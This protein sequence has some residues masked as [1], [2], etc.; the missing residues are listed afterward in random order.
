MA[1]ESFANFDLLILRDGVGYQARVLDSPVGNAKTCFELPFTAAELEHFAWL[2]PHISRHLKSA[3]QSAQAP[4]DVQTFGSRLFGAVF[5]GEVG[6]L[7]VRSLDASK[8]TGLRIRLRLNDV[9]E[10]ADL[11][12]EYLY[13][14]GPYPG[15]LALSTSTP[16]V[17]YLELSQAI[18]PL[19]I[20]SPLRILTVVADPQDVAPRLAVEREWRLLHDALDPLQSRGLVHLERLAQPTVPALQGRLRQH[21][22]EVHILHFIG[23]GAYDKEQTEG[24]LYFENEQGN[25]HFVLATDLAMLLQDHASLRLV[26]LNACEGARS[27]QQNLFAGTAQTLVQRAI[28]AVLAMQFPVSDVAA[29]T[30]AQGFYQSLGSGLPVDV[31]VSEARK[32]LK[33]VG[34][35][36]EW[37]TPVLFSRSADNRILVLPEGDARLTIPRQDWEPE[38]V[39]I[40]GG[41]FQMGSEPGE[42][43]PASET[44]QHTID[45]PDF[46]I[47]KYPVTNAQY[48]VFVK[49][50]KASGWVNVAREAGWFDLSP[51]ATK[52][53][54][55]VTHISWR[56]ALAYCAW[57]SAETGRRYRLPSE[58]E[59]EKAASWSAQRPP[60]KRPY[61]W[62]EGWVAERANI[63]GNETSP[64]TAHPTGASAYGVEDLLGNVQEWTCSLWGSQPQQPDAA[65]GKSREMLHGDDL[66]VQARL[67]HRGGSFNSQPSELRCTARGNA[68]PNSR[69]GWRGF[70]VVMMIRQRERT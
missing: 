31:A 30:L 24:G 43:I 12:W 44:P 28:P 4:L 15:F 13:A 11:P 16:I 7:L 65:P 35:D 29:I 18:T 50:T 39:L 48:A 62:G 5:G 51:P 25:R 70:R 36:V 40:P 6:A 59:W 19:R 52:L 34:N 14:D 37:G 38:T 27:S 20:H 55:P 61:P 33:A 17:R 53:D 23:H 47:G 21:A 60:T 8:S 42:G 54:H 45:L 9:P 46:R 2:P 69:V 49:A 56:D 3:D 1:A 32:T 67:I 22:D 57:L 68:T 26:F 41:P 66:P 64:V 10:L 63:G 58:A